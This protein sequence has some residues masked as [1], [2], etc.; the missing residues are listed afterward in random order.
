[1]WQDIANKNGANAH[2]KKE[3]NELLL[4]LGNINRSS[5]VYTITE[6]KVKQLAIETQDLVD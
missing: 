1:M 2:K 4:G 5:K 3:L 6:N